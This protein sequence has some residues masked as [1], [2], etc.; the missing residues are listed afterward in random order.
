MALTAGL[1]PQLLYATAILISRLTTDS[2]R[3]AIIGVLIA[4]FVAPAIAVALAGWN[5]YCL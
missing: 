4:I 2:D 5:V 1:L 3:S